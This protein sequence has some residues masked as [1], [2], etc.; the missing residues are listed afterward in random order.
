[1]NRSSLQFKMA[2]FCASQSEIGT[3]SLCWLM[4]Y[5]SV[6]FPVKRQCPYSLASYEST[7]DIVMNSMVWSLLTHRFDLQLT[8]D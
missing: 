6:P 4:I 2:A 1:M 8:I 3:C 7:V 5:P